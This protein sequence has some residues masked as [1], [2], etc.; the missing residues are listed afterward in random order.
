MP[1]GDNLRKFDHTGPTYRTQPAEYRAWAGMNTRCYNPAF[2]DWRLYG[3]RG[4]S[5]CEEWRRSFAAFFLAVGSKPTSRHS[6]D[7]WPDGNGNYEPGNVRWATAQEQAEN[8]NKTRYL[9]HA[10]ETLSLSAWAKRL[11][12][13]VAS[14]HERIEKFGEFTALST[15][16]VRSRMRTHGGTFAKA[17][18]N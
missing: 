14:L 16:P 8:T 10:G 2:K 18:S 9:S 1:R 3:G 13:C 15:P 11:G 12:L 17:I 5:V 6:L 4:I 7:R